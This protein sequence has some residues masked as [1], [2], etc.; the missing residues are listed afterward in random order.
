MSF[1]IGLVAVAGPALTVAATGGGGLWAALATG[2]ALAALAGSLSVLGGAARFG[3]RFASGALVVAV[4]L[5]S[6]AVAGYARGTIG[7]VPLFAGCLMAGFAVSITGIVWQSVVQAGLPTAEL[8]VFSSAEGFLTA[9]GVPAGMIAGGSALTATG[10]GPVAAGAAVA[11]LGC[12]VAVG[13]TMRTP[14]PRHV[15]PF[16]DRVA[17]AQRD[18]GPSRR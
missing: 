5:E 11:L 14:D 17:G 9:A 15:D 4:V 13:V 2:M 12:A 3:W 10:I 16:P 1:V 6:V 8:G 7:P 18:R